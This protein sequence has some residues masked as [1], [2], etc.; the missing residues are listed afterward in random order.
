M[1]TSRTLPRYDE[2]E[3]KWHGGL[4]RVSICIVPHLHVCFLLQLV[5]YMQGTACD[6]Y[7]TVDCRTFLI[8]HLFHPPA[9][10]VYAKRGQWSCCMMTPTSDGCRLALKVL[11]SV[12][13]RSITT[14]QPIPTESWAAKFRLTSR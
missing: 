5:P 6:A 2:E 3:N 8:Y 7:T 10:P 14:Q 4:Y 13:S 11:P 9:R 12:V 1:L